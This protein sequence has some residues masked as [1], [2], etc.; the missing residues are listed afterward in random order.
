MNWR[1]F[2][3][4]RRGT[5]SAIILLLLLIVLSLILIVLSDRKKTTEFVLVQN[6]S[7]IQE[8]DTF[9]RDLKKSELPQP[10]RKERQ[11]INKDHTTENNTSESLS[12]FKSNRYNKADSVSASNNYNNSYRETMKLSSGQTISL[13]ETDTAEWKKIPGIGSSYSSRIVKYRN[14]LGGYVRKEQLTEVYGMN[15]DLFLKIT[16]FISEDSAYNKLKINALEFKELLRH[17]YLS[18]KQVQAI[19]NLRKK[20]GS[21]VSI[22]ELSMLNEFNSDDIF[23]IEPYLEF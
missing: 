6:D 7:I 5:K 11:T 14:L 21:I 20:K 23:R 22:N 15:N 18:Y 16:P 4:Y 9:I 12:M 8:F 3:Y 1:D 19:V 10:E 2:F 17:P 13:N